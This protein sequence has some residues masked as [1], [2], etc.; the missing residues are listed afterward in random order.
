MIRRHAKIRITEIWRLRRKYCAF[1]GAPFSLSC[2]LKADDLLKWYTQNHSHEPVLLG[3]T[4]RS[5]ILYV[6]K[7]YRE[8]NISYPLTSKR[9][10]AYHGV[11]NIIFLENLANVLNEWS[12]GN[13]IYFKNCKNL[14]NISNWDLCEWRSFSKCATWGTG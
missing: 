6:G 13:L 4:K 5:F 12:P 11:R 9:T 2:A 3:N 7:I 8:T 1:N 10:C 14:L